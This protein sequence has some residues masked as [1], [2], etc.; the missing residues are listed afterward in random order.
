MESDERDLTHYLREYQSLPFERVAEEFRSRALV[1]A[2]ELRGHT[3][4]LEI[5]CG[6]KSIFRRLGPKYSGV[7]VEPVSALLGLHSDLSPRCTLVNARLEAI[8]PEAFAPL[9][10]I[11]MSSILHE[12]PDPR[13]LV[14]RSLQFTQAGALIF[15]VVPNGLSLHRFV[16]WKKQILTDPLARTATQ[17]LMQQRS[18]VFTPESLME[19]FAECEVSTVQCQTIFPKLLSH[20]QMEQLLDAGT[21]DMNFLET[22][23]RLSGELEPTGSE[24]LY[25]GKK[26]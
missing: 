2:I 5:G 23:D 8:E 17:D 1:K 25:V 13:L 4:L 14:K 20:L 6:S 12:V 24:I 19:L 15:C 26:K 16:G 11:V 21:I 9:E 10:A 22:M 18:A 3:T 7:I